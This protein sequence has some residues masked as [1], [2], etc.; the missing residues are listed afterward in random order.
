MDSV[1]VKTC[2]KCKT[3]KPATRENFTVSKISED[4]LKFLCRVCH[5][6]M[7]KAYKSR[8]YGYDKALAIPSGKRRC[9]LCCWIFPDTPEFFYKRQSGCFKCRETQSAVY[10]NI[11]KN[12]EKYAVTRRAKYWQDPEKARAQAREEYYR[13]LEKNLARNRI[14]KDENRAAIYEQAR[15]A[16]GKN[17][18]YYRLRQHGRRVKIRCGEHITSTDILALLERQKG[19]CWWCRIKLNGK[20]HIDHV[21]PI[22]KGGE[23][24][25]H[26]LCISCPKCNLRKSVKTPLEFAGRL[27]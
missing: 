23:H 15:Q 12:K 10:R 14:Y 2:T 22:S 17:C 8:K 7:N 26:N 19:R 9:S 3:E 5:R 20:Y 16:R 1:P 4:G 21:H 27:F 24:A 13:Y 25:M 18:I 6:A 11:G